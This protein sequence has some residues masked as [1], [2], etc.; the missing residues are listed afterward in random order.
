MTGIVDKV[1]AE[2]KQARG[3]DLSGYRRSTLERRLCA[4]MAQLRLNDS[5]AYF[6]KLHS[7]PSEYPH[8]I[9]CILI[10]VS[11]FFRNPI[12]F[13]I[14]AQSILP[15]IIESKR[16]AGLNELRVWCAG[17]AKGEE[18]YSIA[19]LAHQVLQR[20]E[21]DW[22]PYIFATDMDSDSLRQAEEAVFPRESLENT[23]L[24]ILDEYFIP[25]G[26]SY[27]V[28]PQIREM[29]RF[30]RYDLT[31]P[32]TVAPAESVF[33]TFDLVS[34]RNV[35]IYFTG[36]IQDLILNKLYKSLDIG[37]YLILGESETLS[38]GMKPVFRTIDNRNRIFMK[39]I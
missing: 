11:S 13:E 10:N 7:D 9:D 30:S 33:G 3:I 32:K 31:S 37:G 12:V 5:E 16:L 24:C 27:K 38:P 8:L 6:R 17:C 20:E 39:Q 2:L 34:C 22:T 36:E 35:L 4:R 14:V 29:V 1:L 23:K 25:Q 15:S 21:Q 18:A 28:C 26:N 19:I